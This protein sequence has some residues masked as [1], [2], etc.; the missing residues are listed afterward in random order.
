M[1]YYIPT[2]SLNFNNIL[3]TESISPKAFYAER[4]F[5]Y[6]RWT[7]IPENNADGAVVLYA[8]PHAFNRPKSDVEDHPML[9]EVET[10]ERF[11]EAGEGMFYSRHTIY[12][13]PWQTRIIFF[14]EQ[15]KRVTLSLSDS[16]LETKT[17]RLYLNKICV[18][19]FEGEYST[20]GMPSFDVDFNEIKKDKRINRMKGLLYGYYIGANLSVSTEWVEKQN[21]LTEIH[22]IFSAVVSSPDKVPSVAQNNR[23]HELFEG[24]NKCEPE[25]EMLRKELGSDEKVASVYDILKRC[26]HNIQK[27]DENRMVAGLRSD[28]EPVNR[29]IRW[30]REELSKHQNNTKQFAQKLQP[31]SRE[32]STEERTAVRA[33]CISDEGLAELYLAWVN[34]I[35]AKDEY[36]G[37]VS[38]FKERLSDDLT[39]KAK[40]VIGDELWPNSAVRTFMND[41]RRHVRGEAFEHS[42]DNGVLSSI[43]AVLLKGDDWNDMLRFM[44]GKGMIDYRLAFSFYGVLNGFANLTR[45][46]TDALFKEES[47]Y[48][49]DVYREFYGQLHDGDIPLSPADIIMEKKAIVEDKSPVVGRCV[50][51]RDRVEEIIKDHPRVKDLEKDIQVI[52]HAFDIL[53]DNVHPRDFINQIDNDITN[54]KSGIFPFL[55]KELA[56]DYKMPTGRKR[57]KKVAQEEK[58]G[59]LFANHAHEYGIGYMGSH[60]DVIPNSSLFVEDTNVVAFIGSCGWL[61]Q[62]MQRILMS[63]VKSFQRDYAV[64]GYYYKGNPRT[65]DNT[66]KHFINKCTYASMGREPWIQ[67]NEENERLLRELKIEL[68]KRYGN[69]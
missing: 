36:N 56:P 16:S 58:Q 35:L 46:F 37:K 30:I 34:D 4:G 69:R 68:Q 54:T 2:S 64:D 13:N 49:A 48:L 65:N 55:Q 67:K 20:I 22:D 5:G 60:D 47:R 50:T 44:Q 66:I 27:Y 8:E 52:K 63:K 11:P 39:I 1:K 9:V 45:D 59:D 25:W 14:S 29:S 61:P 31:K 43:A 33:S 17:L 62:D 42:W 28:Y 7:N 18:R 23:L 21:I 38:T 15:E 53:G 24:M 57:T 51:L 41:L 10:E 3:S 26:G 32:I 40:E 6:S 12:L 19:T